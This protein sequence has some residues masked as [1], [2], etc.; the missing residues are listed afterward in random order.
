MLPVSHAD[1]I[2]P[3]IVRHIAQADELAKLSLVLE[4]VPAQ[5]DVSL[6]A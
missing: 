4:E 1:A 5:A 2:N 6:K 3:D